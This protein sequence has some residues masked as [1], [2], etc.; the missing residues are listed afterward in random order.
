[1]KL[2]TL[3]FLLRADPKRE[4]LLGLK[5]RGFGHGKYNGFGGKIADGESVREAAVREVYEECG[6][7]VRPDDLVPAGRLTFRFP[8]R[9]E[10]DHHVHVFRVETWRGA[11]RESDEMLPR[12]FPIDGIPYD[13]MWQ[14]DAQWLPLVLAGRSVDAA[15]TFADDNETLA[16]WTMQ[17]IAP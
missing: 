6:L 11:L 16:D 15:F 2:A 3:S 13:R 12:W 5:K 1:M 7:V 10:F 4:I 14:D 8:A 9:S 17:R